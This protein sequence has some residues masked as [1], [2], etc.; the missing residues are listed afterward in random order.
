[1]P[2]TVMESYESYEV[3]RRSFSWEFP[4]SYN[5]AIDLLAKHDARD[6]ALR[7]WQDGSRTSLS[8][9]TLHDRA[10]AVAGGLANRGIGPGDRVGVMAPQ[11]SETLVSHC[12]LWM[13]GAITIP[14]TTLFGHEALRHRLDDAGAV[15]LIYDPAVQETVEAVRED[16]PDLAHL[17]ELGNTSRSALPFRDLRSESSTRETPQDTS[18]ATPSAIMYTSGTTGSPKG[19]LHRHALWLG[20]A[21]AAACFFEGELGPETVAWTPADWAWGGALGGLVFATWH[22][23]GTVVADRPG[24]FDPHEAF[25]TMAAES[26][27]HAFIPPTA[28]RMLMTVDDPAAHYDLELSVIASA[29]EPVTPEILEWAAQA[30]EGVPV[31]EFY[32]Q[33]ELNLVVAT[34]GHWFDRRPGRMGR[35]LPGYE[36]A[37]VDEDGTEVPEGELGEI[38]VRPHDDRVVF[39]EY[40]GRPEETAAKQRGDWYLTGD[41]AS[42]DD[43]YLTFHSRKDDLI[44]TSGYRVGPGEVEEAILA[45]SDVEQAGVIGVPDE[46][47]GERIKAFVESRT[48]ADHDRLRAEIRDLVRDRLAA[49][50]YPRE[51]E[52]VESLPRTSTGKIQRS[53]LRPSNTKESG[54]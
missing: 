43:G 45:H 9:G 42:V 44:I 40:W 28:L 49:Y 52:F 2:W 1:M 29:G 12:A 47:R 50:E 7:S 27:T 17:I 19:V 35:P 37:V 36:V 20:R 53:A 51:I 48:D 26:I 8:F 21:A 11:R 24:A 4:E 30:L 41:L 32:G 3:A 31:N 23:G 10:T 16:C 15:G 13:R 18:V 22:H 46:L 6:V 38:A 54:E 5:P 33:T 34:C 25:E 14:L 39:K